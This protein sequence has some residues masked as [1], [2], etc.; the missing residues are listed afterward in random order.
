MVCSV[1]IC[2]FT[3]LVVVEEKRL[4]FSNPSSSGNLPMVFS[5]W[6]FSVAEMVKYSSKG[7]GLLPNLISTSCARAPENAIK[8]RQKSKRQRFIC[9]GSGHEFKVTLFRIRMQLF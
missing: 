8:R 2:P 7:T 1:E 5:C 4:L 3:M 9:K 6:F